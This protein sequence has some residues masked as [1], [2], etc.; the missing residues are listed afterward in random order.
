M[1]SFFM[2]IILRNRRCK[3]L[4]NPKHLVFRAIGEGRSEA[5]GASG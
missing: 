3:S 5:G 2:E 4:A 1:A